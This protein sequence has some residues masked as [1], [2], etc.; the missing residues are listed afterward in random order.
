MSERLDN[1]VERMVSLYKTKE[2]YI[3][4]SVESNV[5]D[6]EQ[7]YWGVITDPDGKSR[8]RNEEREQHLSDLDYIISFIKKQTSGYLLEVGCGIGHFLYGLYQIGNWKIFGSEISNYAAE[9]ASKYGKIFVGELYDGP[10]K[11][12]M[13]DIVIMHHVIEHMPDPVRNIKFV[14]KILK[15]GGTLI[16]GTPDFDSACA[17]R[18]GKNYRLLEDKTHTS[19]FSNDSMHRFLRDYGFDIDQVV[20]PF[21]ETRFF[22]KEN[23]IR[24]FNTD[25]ISP[26]FCGNFM[27]FFAKNTD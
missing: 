2:Y 10:Y 17:R 11:E 7:N 16:L 14:K 4:L 9:R 15:P 5:P 3:H 24:L 22:T 26:P 25:L 19:L 1:I 21:F 23:L 20:Y 6:Y 12:S 8:K 27:T 18:F 13:F